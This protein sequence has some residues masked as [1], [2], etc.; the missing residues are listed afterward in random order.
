MRGDQTYLRRAQKTHHCR[1]ILSADS[2]C[3]NCL[4]VRLQPGELTG[5]R[6]TYV[7]LLTPK[8]SPALAVL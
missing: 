2:V 3:K 8:H 6:A 7:L 4:Q 5:P 1:H